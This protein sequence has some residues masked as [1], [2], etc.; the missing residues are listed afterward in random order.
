MTTETALPHPPLAQGLSCPVCP[1]HD[2]PPECL[3]CENCGTDLSPIRRV[4]ELGYVHYNRAVQHLETGDASK[5]IS[6]LYGA[7]VT[8][9]AMANARLLLGK[10]LWKAGNTDEAIEQWRAVARDHP[11]N[12]HVKSLLLAE[13][14]DEPRRS[15]NRA[16]WFAVGVLGAVAVFAAGWLGGEWIGRGSEASALPPVAIQAGGQS[17]QSS[18]EG[19]AI[20]RD[21]VALPGSSRRH[22]SGSGGTQSSP[23]VELDRVAERLRGLGKLKVEVDGAAIRVIPRD[24]LFPLGSAMP[25]GPGTAL[26]KELQ[27]TIDSVGTPLTVITTGFADSTPVKAGGRWRDNKELALFRGA[28]ALSLLDT[29]SSRHRY[30][31]SAAGDDGTA[32]FTHAVGDQSRSRTVTLEIRATPDLR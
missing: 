31:A 18:T 32:F 23:Q 27:T 13:R 14:Q 11:D 2:I 8:D 9:P 4:L 21:S 28:Q 7:I 10:L 17:A 25:N 29:N 1:A 3:V 20:I 30:L 24:G 19:K 15:P 16:R 6:E 5:A 22:D 12:E 26:L